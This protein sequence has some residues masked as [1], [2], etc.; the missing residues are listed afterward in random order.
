MGSESGHPDQARFHIIRGWMDD[1]SNIGIEYEN[2]FYEQFDD[3]SDNEWNDFVKTVVAIIA[4]EATHR[5]QMESIKEKYQYETG[6]NY[7]YK[8]D[9]AIRSFGGVPTDI[10]KYMSNPHEIAAFAR[11]AVEELRAV[12]Y[13]D[14]RI[15]E[16][17][18]N[19]EELKHIVGDAR[20]FWRYWDFFGP[21]DPVFTRLLQQMYKVLTNKTAA[22]KAEGLLRLHD[23]IK[24]NPS[25]LRTRE[26]HI[27]EAVFERQ[28]P[29]LYELLK[30]VQKTTRKDERIQ[31]ILG[32]TVL[33]ALQKADDLF[34]KYK[35]G[36]EFLIDQALTKQEHA[37]MTLH[38]I[39]R[40][41][42]EVEQDNKT[43]ADVHNEDNG[44]FEPW[45]GVD[46]DGTLAEEQKPFQEYGIGAPV[47]AM[48]KKVQ[49]AIA[50]GELVKVFT[51]RLAVP[52][53]HD[54]L[55]VVI[56]EWTKKFVG[57]PLDSTCVK[58]PGMKEIW[59]DRARQVVKDTG[60]FKCASIKLYRGM[61][62][63]E[64]QN[65]LKT[66]VLQPNP[67]NPHNN[68]T[69][70]LET[71][72]FYTKQHDDPGVVVE[73][74]APVD[75]V[76]E[77]EIYKGDYR[78]IKPVPLEEI[79]T[80]GQGRDITR[81]QHSDHSENDITMTDPEHPFTDE[82]E[83]VKEAKTGLHPNHN[84]QITLPPA[85]VAEV[86]GASKNI[87]DA[88]LGIDGREDDPHITV[89]FGVRDDIDTLANVV[90]SV[91]PFSVTLGKLKVFHA[92]GEQVAVVAEAQSPELPKLHKLVDKA[93]GHRPDDWPY[94]AHVTLAYV[95]KEFSKKYEGS[96]LVEGLSFTANSVTL[97]RKGGE[98]TTIPLG[99]KTAATGLSAIVKTASITHKCARMGTLSD[100]QAALSDHYTLDHAKGGVYDYSTTTALGPSI[101][102][103]IA[104]PDGTVKWIRQSEG[105]VK[106]R[107]SDLDKF[108]ATMEMSAGYLEHPQT[109]IKVKG[110]TLSVDVGVKELV[111]FLG[112][113]PGVK[114]TASCQGE[115]GHWK[116][117]YVAIQVGDKTAANLQHYLYSDEVPRGVINSQSRYSGGIAI[118]WKT[119]NYPAVLKAIK[120]FFQKGATAS[121]KTPPFDDTQYNDQEATEGSNAYDAV[122]ERVKGVYEDF[123]LEELS[124]GIFKD[125]ALHM[126][127]DDQGENDSRR[128]FR[129]YS[130]PGQDVG[131]GDE[132]GWIEVR[133]EGTTA[134]V[135]D[136]FLKKTMR[137][138]GE[139]RGMYR[140]VFGAL[141]QQ[142]ITDVQTMRSGPSPDAR[143]AWESLKREFPIEEFAPN[144]F[145]VH[146]AA[147]SD[148]KDIDRELQRVAFGTVVALPLKNGLIRVMDNHY[149]VIKPHDCDPV[150]LYMWL[151]EQPDNV[152]LQTFNTG[153]QQF[154][155][156]KTAATY[157]SKPV[158]L[159][160]G[161]GYWLSYAKHP[162]E[163]E[164]NT[165]S[166]LS[167]EDKLFNMGEITVDFYKDLPFPSINSIRLNDKHQGKG[168]GRHIIQALAK[169]YGGLTSDPQR[170]TNDNAI[171]MWRGIPGVEEVPSP[172]SNLT[173][174]G[175]FFVLKFAKEYNRFRYATDAS[176]DWLELEDVSDN[177]V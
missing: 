55:Q 94:S 88:E 8:I 51:A 173:P 50:L 63:D 164:S 143:R 170:N 34:A 44:G 36:D 139:G 129:F 136:V 56:R 9:Q 123:P 27:A 116:G 70:D 165:W 142:G 14:E 144:Q 67:H 131:P 40:I 146:L 82:M 118:Y 11:E 30:Q 153:W 159:N 98:R 155:G 160:L 97:S 167:D 65:L 119:E 162:V 108:L 103:L 130:G 122:H 59:D 66:H 87:P 104:Q 62:Q 171:R 113:L 77:D 33:P 166:V 147:A 28:Q 121:H 38:N 32:D 141:R 68:C 100:Y 102:R 53:T 176:G 2:D 110:K 5:N 158:L 4:H 93:I 83:K 125:A 90:E 26:T 13:S 19:R 23:M 106:T 7:H 115:P 69:Q 17:L 18:R 78:L 154:I 16:T 95:K 174:K 72:K 60:E 75:A 112:N 127:M 128:M 89:K 43:A 152:D 15:L 105:N 46:L 107:G 157:Q 61:S 21:G 73:F 76:I 39:I 81:R 24:N 45:I 151:L 80:A 3:M 124:P 58:D 134:Y 52:E 64:Y 175:T 145:R 163:A 35:D 135:D 172:H 168:L 6:A 79:K 149:D 111:W 12:G 169:F 120:A 132:L 74:S 133:I 161:D 31:E 20:T 91:M 47:P 22:L 1:N 126:E 150:E 140:Q 10:F 84:V 156:G 48:V 137:G 101:V 37:L 92:E 148:I 86:A 138:H 114:T 29:A 49:D 57:V 117:G 71:A 99:K 42:N 85:A 25:R 54:R 96:A 109:Y 41:L 177:E